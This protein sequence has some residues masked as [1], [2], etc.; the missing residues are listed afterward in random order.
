MATYNYH[1]EIDV[2]GEIEFTMMAEDEAQAEQFATQRV[3]D[4]IAE[5][6][7]SELSNGRS[8]LDIDVTTVEETDDPYG[9]I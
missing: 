5:G 4:A 7:N 3:E 8:N 9:G 1:I 6:L 2:D